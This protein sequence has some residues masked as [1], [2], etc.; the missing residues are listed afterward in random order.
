M[1]KLLD[2]AKSLGSVIGLSSPLGKWILE[3]A[4]TIDADR[5]AVAPGRF[6][7]DLLVWNA[8]TMEWQPSTEGLPYLTQASWAV[9][10][11]NGN[12]A[13]AGTPA[14]P[15]K[16]LAELERR[17]FSR[18]ANTAITV[19]LLGDFPGQFIAAVIGM[20]ANQRITWRA[21]PTQQAT[22][23][24]TA[25]TPTNGATQDARLAD[26]T[27]PIVWAAH[28]QR[29]VRLTSGANAGAYAWVLADLGANTARVSQF[30]S[31]T[32][33]LA[34][35][36]AVNNTFAIETL[37]TRIAGIDCRVFNG[38]GAVENLAV[39]SDAPGGRLSFGACPGSA[40]QFLMTGCR[41]QT[42]Q[43]GFIIGTALRL[44]GCS[45]SATL[46]S[47]LAAIIVSGHAGFATLQANQGRLIFAVAASFMQNA[48]ITAS[49]GAFVSLQS[50]VGS[51]D[52]AGAG[53]VNV[54]IDVLAQMDNTALL[55]GLNNTNTGPAVQ[56]RSR[57][58]LTWSAVA[59]QP[60]ITSAGGDVQV[61]GAA[62]TTWAAIAGSPQ[63]SIVNANNGAQAGLK[64]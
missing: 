59:T 11:V 28:V 42:N 30:I 6:T 45:N 37:T 13:N 34:V 58:G 23:I 56:I 46:S 41:F 19:D 1:G 61:G 48:Q 33:L 25:F 9:D 49:L 52:R 64:S 47:G 8:A 10:S 53:V 7:G 63:S 4:T 22:G 40:S 17:L 39:E 12:D 21:T 55:W 26:T 57:G 36:P 32:T 62:V 16:T 44:T 27:T 43:A 60:T 2:I 51:F 54:L 15:L 31:P 3:V 29:R 18:T 14:A 38:L 5:A 50:A 35:S 20:S 24:V